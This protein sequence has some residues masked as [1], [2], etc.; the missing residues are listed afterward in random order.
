MPQPPI[1]SILPGIV[2]VHLAEA[3]REG[4]ETN[5]ATREE[6]FRILQA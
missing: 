6:V 4:Q 3:I 2:Q 5:I 1:P